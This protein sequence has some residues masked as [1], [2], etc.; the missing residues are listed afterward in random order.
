MRRMKAF[1]VAVEMDRGEVSVEAAGFASLLVSSSPFMAMWP[2]IQII[3]TRPL[4]L[5]SRWRIAFVGAC[6][7][8]HIFV[9]AVEQVANVQSRVRSGAALSSSYVEVSSVPRIPDLWM[10]TCSAGSPLAST[11]APPSRLFLLF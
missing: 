1:A 10:I 5:C 6:F 3:M 7:S 9:L 2:G 4:L 8:K 11:M